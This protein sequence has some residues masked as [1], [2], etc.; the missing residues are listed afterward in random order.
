ML[1]GRE[2]IYFVIL[3]TSTDVRRTYVSVSLLFCVDFS[4]TVGTCPLPRKTVPLVPGPP[5]APAINAISVSATAV[6]VRRVSV[7]TCRQSLTMTHV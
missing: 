7:Y 3:Q 4:K 5:H 2:T 1:S 6:T